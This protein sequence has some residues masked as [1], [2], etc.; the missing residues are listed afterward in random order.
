MKHIFNSS[1]LA[2]KPYLIA[3]IITLILFF[4]MASGPSASEQ[5]AEIKANTPSHNEKELTAQV[6]VETRYGSNIHKIIE[7]YGR[8]EPDRI[9]TLKAELDGK[10]TEV[11]AK[12]GSKV[13]K[14]QVIAK[15][16][17][18]GL[19]VQLT[20]SKALLKQREVEYEG[21]LKLSQKGYQGKVQLAQSYAALESVKAE[22]ERLELDIANA[23]VRAPF[24][25][26]LNTRNVEVGDYVKSGDDIAIIA[27]L[28]PLIVRAHVTE[29][30]IS[31]LSVGQIAQVTLLNGE[32]AQGVL[33]YIASVGNDATN[34]FKIEVEIENKNMQLL[35]G[36]SGELTIELAEMS[37]IKISPA[38]LALDESGNIGVKSVKDTIVQ[39]TPIEIIK[40]ESDGI[41][42]TGLGD[43]VDII[44]LGQGF[45]RAGDKVDA[46]FDTAST[47][48][49]ATSADKE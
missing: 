27:D 39:F 18:N 41:W 40:S 49:A 31:Q 6:K 12:R 8:T 11:L 33:R 4:W 34:T 2:Q 30:Q 38:L 47:E 19:P 45:V 24:S 15:I 35:A 22:I 9:A 23:V 36:L 32:K 13:S 10:I 5:K 48:Q 26:I 3:I 17:L 37:A 46:I 28:D 20:S 14:G 1:W 43:Q 29:R 7:L 25:G 21:A 44:V 42:L 16:A